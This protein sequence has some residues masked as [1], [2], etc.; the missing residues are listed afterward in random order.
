MRALTAYAGISQP[1]VSKHLGVLKEVGL[2]RHRKE[3]RQTHYRTKPQG[4][5]PMISW[6]AV[7]AVLQH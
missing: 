4:L 5:A 2:V 1:A 3:G 6:V 7:Y